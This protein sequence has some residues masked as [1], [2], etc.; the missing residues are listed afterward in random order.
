MPENKKRCAW[1][2]Q[3]ELYIR[4]HD[5]EWGR[6]VRDDQRLF[7]MLVLETMQ[8][9]LSWFTILRKRENFRKAFDSFDIGKILDYGEEKI[10]ELLTDSGIIRNRLKIGAVITNARAFVE[11]QREFGS[12]AKYLWGFVNDEPIQNSWQTIA[13]IPVTTELS[14]KISV[15]LKKRGFKFVGST[16]IYAYIQ[17]IGMVNDHTTDCFVYHELI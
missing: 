10:A 16:C 7:E 2:T 1:G 12:F 9:G 5:E 3:S 13:E 8:A 14:D 4:Y 17:S 6:P 15:D 11:V